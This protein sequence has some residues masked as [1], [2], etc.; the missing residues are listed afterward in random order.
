MVNVGGFIMFIIILGGGKIGSNLARVLLSEGH[1]VVLVEQKESRLFVLAEEFDYRAMLGDA[2]ELY[3]LEAAGI[4]RPPDIVIAVTG[5]DEDNIVI[6]QLA[7]ELYQVRRVIARVNDPR[8]QPLFDLLGVA[9]TVSATHAILGLV[10]HEVPQ[11]R[12]AHLLEFKGEGLEII[13]TQ[14]EKG[15]K[16]DGKTPAQLKLPDGIRLSAV[17]HEDGRGEIVR[18]STQLQA[19]DQI[20]A[21]LEP[22]LEGLLC[23]ICS[24]KERFGHRKQ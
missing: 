10:E 4:A 11:H 18:G 3:V 21:I 24:H 7:R 17:T 20:I 8:N 16:A 22:G 2:T 13:E 6:C 12:L 5:D 23:R 15:S 1:E 14:I 19:G 9:P